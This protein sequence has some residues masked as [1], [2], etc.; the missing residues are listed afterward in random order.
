M[1]EALAWGLAHWKEV[2]IAF[3]ML[4]AGGILIAL[5]VPGP[6]PED[7]FESIKKFTSKVSRK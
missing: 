5:L 4:L 7:W 2:V 1:A 3:D 6:H